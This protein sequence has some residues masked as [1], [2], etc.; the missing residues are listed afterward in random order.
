ML[1]PRRSRASGCRRR[2]GL[3]TL[4]Y[5]A[6]EARAYTLRE[7]EIPMLAP[8]SAPVRVLHLSD[9]HMTP[10]QRAKQ[11]WVRDLARLEPDLVVG[12]GD[13]LGHRDA[14]P[15]VVDA[16]GDL[17]DRPGVF[18]FGSNDY[19]EPSMRNPLRYL[20][21]DDG[22]RAPTPPSCPGGSCAPR[23]AAPAGWT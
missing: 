12:T 11:G 23:S 15:V 7:V 3:A 4:G 21:P 17:L 10:D 22:R 6:A 5:A 14:V 20:L 16:L 1:L 9:L 2:A 13:F 18:V 19:Y 8:G